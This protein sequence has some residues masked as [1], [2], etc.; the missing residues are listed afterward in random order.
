MNWPFY[1]INEVMSLDDSENFVT[2]TP[3]FTTGWGSLLRLPVDLPRS[4]GWG[5][6]VTHLYTALGSAFLGPSLPARGALQK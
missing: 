1:P 2:S 5:V 6:A 3:G 4:V